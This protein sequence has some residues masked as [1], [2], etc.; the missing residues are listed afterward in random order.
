MIDNIAVSMRLLREKEVSL[1]SSD[2]LISSVGVNGY[3]PVS[4]N[5]VG[6]DELLRPKA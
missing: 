5:W 6:Q 2:K 1:N 3:I 4:R